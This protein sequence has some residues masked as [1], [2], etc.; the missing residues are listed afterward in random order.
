MKNGDVVNDSIRNFLVNL[1]NNNKIGHS[2]DGMS[3]NEVVIVREDY[4][5]L[6]CLFDNVLDI[7]NKKRGSWDECTIKS[8]AT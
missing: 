7:V 4:G 2:N 1:N 6:F 3:I 5:N 8:Y